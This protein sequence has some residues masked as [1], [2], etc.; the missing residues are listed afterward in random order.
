MYLLYIWLS[1]LI[2]NMNRHVE[3]NFNFY[4]QKR[5]YP[6]IGTSK[7][8]EDKFLLTHFFLYSK[9]IN[10]YTYLNIRVGQQLFFSNP[11]AIYNSE[12]MLAH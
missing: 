8:V 12:N 5:S 2:N 7:N 9:V 3:I 11:F 10:T 4:L 6:L 1:V